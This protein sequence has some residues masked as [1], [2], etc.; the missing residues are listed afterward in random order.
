MKFRGLDGTGDWTFG[1]GLA[2]YASDDK[3]INFNIQTRLKSW[4]GNCFF[5]V[6]AG[7]DWLNLLDKGRKESLLLALRT[8]ILQTEGV[9]TIKSLNYTFDAATRAAIITYEVDTIYSSGFQSQVAAAA[10]AA[11]V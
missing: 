1:R 3:A 10:G 2:N 5:D 6:N 11:A 9:V 8:V 7:V 4:V